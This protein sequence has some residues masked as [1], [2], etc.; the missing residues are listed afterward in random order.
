MGIKDNP[1][2]RDLLISAGM[3]EEVRRVMLGMC[4]FCKTPVTTEDFGDDLSL[5]E[6][7]I[8]G[9]CPKCQDEIFK[10]PDE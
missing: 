1:V 9:M 4:P 7:Q 2:K 6:F 8:S 10:D 5:K 3:S